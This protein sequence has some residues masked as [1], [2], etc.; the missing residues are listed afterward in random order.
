MQ[1]ANS[2]G[3]Y[4][5]FPAKKCK[6]H[7]IYDGKYNPENNSVDSPVLGEIK[8]VRILGTILAIETSEYEPKTP[9]GNENEDEDGD[10]AAPF[11]PTSQLSNLFIDDGTGVIRFTKFDVIEDALVPGEI[12]DA[13]GLLRKWQ[14]YYS[15][16]LEIITPVKDPN[17]WTLRELDILKAEKRHATA[18][19]QPAAQAQDLAGGDIEQQK[20][21]VLEQIMSDTSEEGIHFDTL[22][23]TTGIPEPQLQKVLSD[24]LTESSIFEPTRFRYRA[25]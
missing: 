10:N 23:T 25:L 5:R 13:V 2:R 12:I 17:S 24:L 22:K 14:E 15:V 16:N 11:S 19:Q 3:Q 18:S 6:V 8:R 1:N 7:H 20:D 9:R 4:K 21:F